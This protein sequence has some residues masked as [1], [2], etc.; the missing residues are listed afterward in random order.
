MQEGLRCELGKTTG[1]VNTRPEGTLPPPGAAQCATHRLQVQTSRT[2]GNTTVE[3]LCY[4]VVVHVMGL[5][6]TFTNHDQILNLKRYPNVFKTKNGHVI[7][8]VQHTE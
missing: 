3:K 4:L 1:T 2:R 6:R 7:F 8:F 5:R